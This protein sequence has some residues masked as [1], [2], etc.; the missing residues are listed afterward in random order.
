MPLM[1][2]YYMLVASSISDHTYFN[3]GVFIIISLLRRNFLFDIKTKKKINIKFFH[4][5]LNIVITLSVMLFLRWGT[6]LIDTQDIHINKTLHDVFA[7]LFIIIIAFYVLFIFI[8][9]CLHS[10]KAKNVL[11]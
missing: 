4:E 9:Q 3:W 7:P 5:Q 2:H 6:G 10:K 1:N 8:K 11:K